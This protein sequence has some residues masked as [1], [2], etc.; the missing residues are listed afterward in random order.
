MHYYLGDYDAAIEA[1]KHAVELQPNDHLA[2][3]NL[4]DV[5]WAA[6]RA[7]D[8]KASFARARQLGEQALAVN[9][10]DPY[11]L[12][13]LAWIYAMLDLGAKA[14]DTIDRVLTLAPDDAYS[15]YYDALITLR[16]G[17][18]RRALAALERARA[19]GYSSVLIQ[20]EPHLAALR[21]NPDFLAIV[22]QP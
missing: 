13:D 22:S 7:A 12:M 17:D 21:N 10:S 9:P 4:G 8:S 15:H 14:R 16:A 1:M 20:A 19:A 6:G 3:A 11:T 18:K 2:H 5:L